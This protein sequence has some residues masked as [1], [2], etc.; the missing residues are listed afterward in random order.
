MAGELAEL[1]RIADRNAAGVKHTR[2]TTADL[3]RH[4]E[5][6]TAVVDDLRKPAQGSNGRTTR[7]NGH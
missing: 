5:A 1:R 6:L 3:L 7:T 4:A 2:T